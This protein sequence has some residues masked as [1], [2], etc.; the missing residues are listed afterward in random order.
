MTTEEN[1]SPNKKASKSALKTT[2][3]NNEAKRDID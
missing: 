3:N 2:N 1:V